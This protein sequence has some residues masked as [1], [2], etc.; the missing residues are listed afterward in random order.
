MICEA[1]VNPAVSPN[2]EQESRLLSNRTAA[3]R[4]AKGLLAWSHSGE[5]F[6]HVEHLSKTQDLREAATKLFAA[7]RRLDAAGLEMIVAEPVPEHGLGLAIMERLRKAAA[8]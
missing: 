4:P 1:G 2:V 5:G 8:R 3:P 7:M 6:A